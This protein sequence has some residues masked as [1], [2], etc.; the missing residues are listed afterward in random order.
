M[1]VKVKGVEKFCEVCAEGKLHRSSFGH[2]DRESDSMGVHDVIVTDVAGPFRI[3]T[4]DECVYFLTFVDAHTGY[5]TG[6]LLKHKSEVAARFKEY[7][8]ITANRHRRT[9]KVLRSD[10]GTEFVNHEMAVYLAERGIEHQKTIPNT[11][12]QNGIAERMNQTIMEKVRCLLFDAKCSFDLWGE[13][14]HAS[15][16]LINR[17]INSFSKVSPFQAEF[18][19][20]EAWGSFRRFG[21]SA[22]VHFN[23]DSRSKLD[24][25]SRKLMFVGYDLLRKGWRF[26]DTETSKIVVSRDASFNEQDN[27]ASDVDQGEFAFE[28][29]DDVV[30]SAATLGDIAYVDTASDDDDEIDFETASFGRSESEA[31]SVDLIQE[32]IFV[33]EAEANEL[34]AESDVEDVIEE[35]VGDIPGT[36]TTTRSGRVS[37]KPPPDHTARKATVE[38]HPVPQSYQQYL[39]SNQKIDWTKAMNDEMDGLL[40]NKTWDLV[41]LEKGVKPIGNKW[42][43]SQKTNADGS[44]EKLKARLVVLGNMQKEGI[45]Y[46]ETFAPVLHFNSLRT[47]LAVAVEEDLILHQSDVTRAFLNGDVE[48]M[49]YMQQPKGYHNGKADEVCLLRKSLYGLKQA[50]RQWYKKVSASLIAA[51]F[52]QSK[53]DPCIFILRQGKLIHYLGLYVDD[54]IQASNSRES[55]DQVNQVLDESFTVVQL[56]SPKKVL[57]VELV[58]D[59]KAGTITFGLE[60]FTKNAIAEFLDENLY[61]VSTPQV[62]NAKVSGATDKSKTVETERYRKAVGS[63]IYITSRTRPDIATAVRMASE[64]LCAPTQEAWNALTRIFQY[65]KGTSDFSL[66]YRKGGGCEVRA[67][68]DADWGSCINDRKSVSGCLVKIGVNTVMWKSKK[69]KTVALSTTES[70]Y[71]A[72]VET[73]KEVLWLRQLLEEMGYIQTEATTIY[74]DNI[75]C[76]QLAKNEVT[77]ARSKHIDIRHHFVREKV[78]D[79]VIKLEYVATKENTADILTKG[80]SRL[81]YE[82]HVVDVGLRRCVK[83]GR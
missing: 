44:L 77:L 15:L 68:S 23:D 17:T 35:V 7:E 13:A 50:P 62:Q 39:N 12:Q 5:V 72:L 70:E 38:S 22:F 2:H 24:K 16:Y 67:Y 29:D 80:I 81:S 8:S 76:I 40:D 66:V 45:D 58:Q 4:F 69:Q 55:I 42:V 75:G 63:L 46:N 53:T 59:L 21:C 28:L 61:Q 9:M 71:M 47:L 60:L 79:G 33:E 51:G 10:N 54:F 64:H 14:F 19:Q 73:A 26:Y 31:E 3:P 20:Q 25:R 30:T 48:E 1:G 18:N 11:P 49:I 37:R 6:Y 52:K 32:E 57:G 82:K 83:G 74:D 36:F 43:Y 65:L 56:G 78:A 34:D 41:K 27:Y